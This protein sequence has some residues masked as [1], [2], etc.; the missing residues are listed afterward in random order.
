ME[1]L[2]TD[3]RV[4]H[5]LGYNKNS[6]SKGKLGDSEKHLHINLNNSH[7]YV[8]CILNDTRTAEQNIKCDRW[9]LRL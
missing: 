6:R 2:K 7:N 8:W 9:Y 1:Q 4:F 3:Q 5:L